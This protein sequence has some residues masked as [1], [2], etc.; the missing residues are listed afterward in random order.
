MHGAITPLPQYAFMAWCLVKHRDNFTFYLIT[1]LFRVSSS[2][3][4]S[5]NLKIKIYKTIILPLFCMGVICGLSHM[6]RVFENMV[7]RR[8]FE[9]EW[10][11]SRQNCIIRSFITY[12]LHQILF[13]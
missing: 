9:R 12:T 2:C 6:G 3:L 7:L 1:I 4:L 10:H 8:I 13:R 5:K 11:Q